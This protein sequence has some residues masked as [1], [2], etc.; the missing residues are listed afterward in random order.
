M[1][2]QYLQELNRKCD[3]ERIINI[4][5]YAKDNDVPIINEEGLALLKQVIMLTD[6]TNILEIGTAIGYSAINM[7]LIN[8]NINI[9]TIERNEVMYNKA[10]ENISNFN[11]QGR[12]NTIFDDA[13]NVDESKLGQFDLIFID[14]AKSQY[15]K[16]F[17]KYETTLRGKGIIF[18]DNLIFHNLVVETIKDKNLRQLVTKIKKFSKWLVDNENYDTYIYEIGDGVAI[19]IRK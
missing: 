1:V 15:T 2:K 5:S 8:D 17:E 13:L 4:R 9:T 19:S 12:I 6:S 16:F 11:L 7:A 3:D 10:N 18:T 14:A